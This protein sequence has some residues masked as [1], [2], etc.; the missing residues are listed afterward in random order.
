MFKVHRLVY[1]STLGLRVKKKKKVGLS[2][3]AVARMW[4]M[5]DSHFEAHRLL[6]HSA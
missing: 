5:E 1:H 3:A 2:L 6:Y 4:R